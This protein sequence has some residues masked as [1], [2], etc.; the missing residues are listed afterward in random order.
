MALFL[1]LPCINVFQWFEMYIHILYKGIW[2]NYFKALYT[3][4]TLVYLCKNRYVFQIFHLI[5]ELVQIHIVSEKSIKLE[6]LIKLAELYVAVLSFL[7]T[8]IMKIY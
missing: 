8:L 1:F 2:K 4:K 7:F 5:V 3:K 6:R